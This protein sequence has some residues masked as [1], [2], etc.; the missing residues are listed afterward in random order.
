[1]EAHEV[2]YMS[3]EKDIVKALNEIKYTII[4]STL[5]LAFLIGGLIGVLL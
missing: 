3:D 4:T 2:G 5:L 1:M